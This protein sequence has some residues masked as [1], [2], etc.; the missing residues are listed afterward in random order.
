MVRI[1]KV[2][3][4]AH[5]RHYVLPDDV[6]ALAR[7]VWLHRLLLDPEAE[8]AGTTAETVIARVVEKVAAPRPAP[9]D[10]APVR[11]RTAVRHPGPCPATPVPEPQPRS[12]SFVEGTSEDREHA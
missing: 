9:P 1:A 12:L 8:F 4:A 3:A 5:G 2:W 6:K 7:P 10:P 11:P